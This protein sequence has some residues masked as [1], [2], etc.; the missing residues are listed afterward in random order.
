MKEFYV[1]P[2]GDD[3]NPG[4]LAEP[5]RTVTQG[6]K[7]LKDPGDT[8]YLRQGIYLEQV[9]IVDKH[10]ADGAPIVIRSYPG[11]HACI[12]SSLEDF[13]TLNSAKW[14]LASLSDPEAHPD[15]YIWAEPFLSTP[16][17]PLNRGAFLDYQ[18]Y[19]RLITYSNIRDFRSD[20]ETFV[21][22]PDYPD[23]D[24][25]QGPKVLEKC[26]KTNP[27]PECT[28]VQDGQPYK[29]ALMEVMCEDN[30]LD[31]AC[32]LKN[33]KR[34]KSV[35]YR[36]PWSYMGP[37]L[38]FD[39]EAHKVHIRLS[40]THN[41]VP[42]VGD[43]LGETDP[44]Q[45]RLAI[46][47]KLMKTLSITKSE[48]VRLE[49]LSIRFGGEQTINLLSSKY[50]VF[51]HVRIWASPF[52]VRMGGDVTKPATGTVFQHCEFD[53]GLPAWFFRND[54]KLE[55]DFI[56]DGTIGHNTRGKGTLDSLI[57]GNANDTGT[58]IHHCEFHDAHDL[59]LYGA[60]LEFHHNWIHNLNDEGMFLDSGLPG[61]PQSYG[62]KIYQNVI[63]KTQSAISFAGNNDNGHWYVFRN[64]VDLRTPTAG[65]RPRFTGDT[66]VWRFGQAF[67]ISSNDGDRDMFQNTFLV[68]DQKEQASYLHYRDTTGDHTR[69]T[70]NNIFIAIN[71]DAGSDR[72]IT[73]I[74]SP[75]FHGPTDG[76]DYHRIGFKTNP[77][78]RY[79]GYDFG[80]APHGAGS[81]ADLDKFRGKPGSPPIPPS[82]LFLQSQTQY[83]PGYEANSI[84]EDP[85]FR[86]F[87]TDGI[88]QATDDLRLSATSPA[89]GRGVA[90]PMDLS[91]LDTLAPADSDIR[92]DIGC[93]PRDSCP[94]QVGVEGRRSYP[95]S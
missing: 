30:D 51:D 59:Y 33:G 29:L 37:G 53:G 74:P 65:F 2:S 28:F 46:S 71:P 1:S 19:T 50:V 34:V 58:Q 86:Q 88:P 44:N 92:P 73:F 14:E 69:R 55:Y 89:L 85:Q 87:H 39:R 41:N 15:E 70:F 80:G 25:R 10:G 93:F 57:V 31:P 43:Y 9:N 56:W 54:R 35:P 18:T 95:S 8:L 11:E 94:L 24:P 90:L 4:N 48:H 64:L 32:T 47:S 21:Q 76:N 16:N 60:E 20:V 68:Y 26:S 75:S 23:Q 81:F 13:R 27:G 17:D 78:L 3:A 61:Q 82:K 40:H 66:N 79:L 67:K 52:G 77:L 84:A 45:L 36:Y 38:W 7:A 72:P 5:F 12:D 83:P 91:S 49:D 63:T 42:G 6:V 22:M 62:M